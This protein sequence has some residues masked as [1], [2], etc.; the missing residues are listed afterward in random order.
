MNAEKIELY[1]LS[2]DGGNTFTRQWQSESDLK[3][4]KRLFPNIVIKRVYAE[5]EN[6]TK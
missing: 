6:K 5:R 4:L 2:A 1:D 3:E